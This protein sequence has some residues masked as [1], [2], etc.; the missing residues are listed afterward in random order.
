M[1]VAE[2]VERHDGA[3]GAAADAEHDEIFEFLAHVL[4]RLYN[5]VY[6]FVL[7]IGQFG[8]AHKEFVFAAVLRHISVRFLRGFF[9][10]FDF[11]LRNTLVA[12]VFVG[13]VGVINVKGERFFQLFRQSHDKF[14]QNLLK[15]F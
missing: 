14:L 10:R 3:E 5:V 2:R 9:V 11:L 4:R 13:H 15:V 12:E 8:P 6:D 7:I 1:Q